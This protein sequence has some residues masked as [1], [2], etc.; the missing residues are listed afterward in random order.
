MSSLENIGNNKISPKI[1]EYIER[2][3]SGK[4]KIEDF[5][6]IPESWKKIILENTQLPKDTSSE[7]SSIPDE[8]EKTPNDPAS[9]FVNIAE[10]KL[11]SYKEIISIEGKEINLE[12]LK[13]L[14]QADFALWLQENKNEL[15]KLTKEII[16]INNKKVTINPIGSNL[17]YYSLLTLRPE[18]RARA[19]INLESNIIE[20]SFDEAR[21]YFKTTMAEEGKYENSDSN[22]DWL[23]FNFGDTRNTE[24]DGMRRKGYITVENDSIENFKGNIKNIIYDLQNILPD[25]YNGSLKISQKLSTLLNQFDNIVVHGAND[26]EVDKALSLISDTLEKN[27]ILNKIIQKGK[28]GENM[29]GQKTSHTRLL[30]EKIKN[31]EL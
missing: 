8:K 29:K 22:P 2:I 21:D 7:L 25:K 5:G 23:Q 20:P 18:Y 24:E 4:E 19:I 15:E 31:Q 26:E 16:N 11:I 12:H 1:Q 6:D 28:D 10:E 3:N 27:G 30:E 14:S 13:D 17:S 9:S